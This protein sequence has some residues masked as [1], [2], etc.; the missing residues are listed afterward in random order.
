MRA[1]KLEST[2]KP[3][4]ECGESKPLSEFYTHSQMADGHLNKC[5]IC[6]KARV[7]KH[8]NENI[9]AVREYDRGRNFRDDR[10][11][12]RKAY[13]EEKKSCPEAK[14][15]K[16]IQVKANNEKRPDNR[17]ARV[18]VGNA[19]RDGILIRPDNCERCIQ[20]IHTDAHHEDYSKPLDVVWLCEPCHGMRHR[21]INAERRASQPFDI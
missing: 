10:V 21:E 4:R 6:V 8:R 20:A 3:C 17:K 5:K 2:T 12:A 18:V 11:E 19:I 13:A 1:V 15:R 7:E 9:E 14:A 16:C